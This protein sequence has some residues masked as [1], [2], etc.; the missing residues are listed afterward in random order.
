MS[1]SSESFD[2]EHCFSE[3]LET[4]RKNFLLFVLASLTLFIL[5]PLTFFII[6]GPIQAGFMMM[7]LYSIRNEEK[8]KFDDL[9]KY[10]NKFGSLILGFFVP[11]ICCF[12]GLF[13]LV[14]PGF[15]I[16][17][18]WMYVLLLIIDNDLSVVDALRE[19]YNIVV[20]NNIW[21]HIIL[22][23]MVLVIQSIVIGIHPGPLGLILAIFAYPLTTGLI[24][25][26]YN[27]ISSRESAETKDNTPVKD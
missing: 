21:K 20:K 18:V 10:F 19:S 12:I 13:F 15:L 9:F 5:G 27:Q 24:V 26:A 25:S 17:T 7:I 3:S 23:L 11:V 2:V 6:M 1:L 8:P 4:Y 22:L 14:V 16:I